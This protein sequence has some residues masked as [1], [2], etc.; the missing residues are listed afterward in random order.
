MLNIVLHDFYFFMDPNCHYYYKN[1]QYHKCERILIETFQLFDKI[2]LDR[3]NIE[4]NEFIILD[5]E[6]QLLKQIFSSR[7]DTT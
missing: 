1:I 2:A 5:N 7:N 4:S 3:T 6:L